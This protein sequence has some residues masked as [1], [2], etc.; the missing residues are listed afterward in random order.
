MAEAQ[1]SIAVSILTR[2]NKGQQ[3]SCS[4][5]AIKVFKN[6]FT[7]KIPVDQR[8]RF[9][10]LLATEPNAATMFYGMDDESREYM[11]RQY[12]LADNSDS[13]DD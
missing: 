2:H 13:D 5:E 4:D 12:L 1:E 9:I 7:D 10:K 3:L 6:M 11:V 8:F